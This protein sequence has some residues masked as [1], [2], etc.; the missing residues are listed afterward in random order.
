MK[1]ILLG[2]TGK[3]SY[4]LGDGHLFPITRK[5][6][7]PATIEFQTDEE[8]KGTK[9]PILI[10]MSAPNNYYVNITDY[11]GYTDQ[12][13]D[14]EWNMGGEIVRHEGLK[15]TSSIGGNFRQNIHPIPLTIEKMFELAK[16]KKP[17]TISVT[18]RR[19]RS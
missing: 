2:Y 6:R 7:P 18:Y 11:R 12:I 16:N 14:V 1:I 15:P 13:F 17:L 19:G 4:L 10:N 5:F 3:G 8:D 9:T